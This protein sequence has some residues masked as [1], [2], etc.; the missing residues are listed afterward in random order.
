MAKT[1]IDE[2]TRKQVTDQCRVV[3]HLAKAIAGVHADLA[4]TFED[5]AF[6]QIIPMVG[7]RTAAW[8]EIL[9]NMLDGIDAVTEDDDWT[10]PVFEE[11]QR[12]WP[13]LASTQGAV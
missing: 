10:A 1:E 4:A 11:S 12:R 7:A 9:G 8:M 2:A 13:S 6:G 3:A 5:G